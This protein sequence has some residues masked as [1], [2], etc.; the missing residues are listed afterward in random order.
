MQTACILQFVLMMSIMQPVIQ[1]TLPHATYVQFFGPTGLVNETYTN[2]V[3]KYQVPV[4][5]QANSTSG[6]GASGNLQSFSGLAFVYGALNLWWQSLSNFWKMITV[7]Y[8]GLVSNLNFL[9]YAITV[10]ASS[11]IFSYVL[12]G[13]FYKLLSGWQKTDIENV[14]A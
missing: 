6:F 12:I 8:S 11:L 4:L 1:I 3:N 9:P 5:N 13:D 14:G 10:T 7:I 2:Y